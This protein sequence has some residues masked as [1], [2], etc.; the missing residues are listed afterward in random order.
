MTA[1]ELKIKRRCAY[2]NP[3]SPYARAYAKLLDVAIDAIAERDTLKAMND[4]LTSR[5][6]EDLHHENEELK[7][8]QE[9]LKDP[10]LKEAEARINHL[11]TTIKEFKDE[12]RSAI[13][14]LFS[15]HPDYLH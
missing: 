1:R 9:M 15:V 14:D 10:K 6:F 8:S 12:I 5:G 4:R 13:A 7:A 3:I 2:A 11:T